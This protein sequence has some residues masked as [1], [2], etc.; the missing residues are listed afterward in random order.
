MSIYKALNTDECISTS[1][2]GIIGHVY[3]KPSLEL[4]K[5]PENIT[6][7]D[8]NYSN[9]I[10]LQNKVSENCIGYDINTKQIS[11]MLCD[12]ENT[13]F[14]LMQSTGVTESHKKDVLFT[15]YNNE[16]NQNTYKRHLVPK[17]INPD[18]VSE[19][20]Y[21]IIEKNKKSIDMANDDN[22]DCYIYFIYK[23][24]NSEKKKLFL[25]IDT[26][27]GKGLPSKPRLRYYDKKSKR[28]V[29]TL[30][31]SGLQNKDNL[32]I[33]NNNK[34]KIKANN[35][36]L[37]LDKNKLLLNSRKSTVFSMTLYGY[38]D[39]FLFIH[40]LNS[41]NITDT[42]ISSFINPKK[43]LCDVDDK[44]GIYNYN[45]NSTK[46][47]Y[48]IKEGSNS[49]VRIGES[50][51]TRY[52]SINPTYKYENTLND[53]KNENNIGKKRVI[54]KNLRN[55][56]SEQN[57]S[58]GIF[59]NISL[60]TDLSLRE[61]ALKILEFILEILDDTKKIIEH[62]F[63]SMLFPSFSNETPY[64][65][66]FDNMN[67]KNNNLTNNF[68]KLNEFIKDYKLYV[69]DVDFLINT[70]K[71]I[72]LCNAFFSFMFNKELYI[73]G[74]YFPN[75][76]NIE[77]N[78]TKSNLISTN[79]K[80][81]YTGIIES[82]EE[83]ISNSYDVIYQNNQIINAIGEF[84]DYANFIFIDQNKFVINNNILLKNSKLPFISENNGYIYVLYRV[85]HC[86]D[87]YFTLNDKLLSFKNKYMIDEDTL[88]TYDFNKLKSIFIN[89]DIESSI[90]AINEITGTSVS[91]YD[92]SALNILKN[93]DNV[94]DL[95]RYIQF[96]SYYNTNINQNIIN[97]NS[98]SYYYAISTL[99]N[100]INSKMI[101]ALNDSYCKKIDI[102]SGDSTIQLESFR[103]KYSTNNIKEMFITKEGFTVF[104]KNSENGGR[105]SL[106]KD[107]SKD[108][109]DTTFKDLLKDIKFNANDTIFTYGGDNLTS[110]VSGNF[111]KQ[112]V[113]DS[114]GGASKCLAG[115]G[116]VR[117]IS[118][119]LDYSCNNM[120][121]NETI[122][123]NMFITGNCNKS[124]ECNYSLV[125]ESTVNG[126][127]IELALNLYKDSSKVSSIH[128]ETIIDV[129]MDNIIPFTPENGITSLNQDN[130][131]IKKSSDPS[132]I[133][134]NDALYSTDFKFRY[135]LMVDDNNNYLKL[136]YRTSPCKNNHGENINDIQYN[137]V[138]N[139][140]NDMSMNAYDKFNKFGY[141][142]IKGHL[143]EY[144]EE[145]I[146]LSNDYISYENYAYHTD[147]EIVYDVNNNDSN[148]IGYYERNGHQISIKK[149]EPDS[150]FYP[151]NGGKVFLKK[152]Y[153]NNNSID[154][155]CPSS[156]DFTEPTSIKV[157]DEYNTTE[158]VTIG[159]KCGIHDIS[160]F[161]KMKNDY[162]EAYINLNSTIEKLKQTYNSL[163]EQEKKLNI[164]ILDEIDNLEKNI[165]KQEEIYNNINNNK[166]SK[167]K[168]DVAHIETK[169]VF[170]KNELMFNIVGII[171]LCA[172]V[173]TFR[174][175]K[176]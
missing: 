78:F 111:F 147:N 104:S 89:I 26:K 129:K 127:N 133:N 114:N 115:D 15:Y 19:F 97:E 70:M 50:Q 59:F 170:D 73:Q 43:S 24:K 81:S 88:I 45:S 72:E 61:K 135:I 166:K 64:N 99:L 176:K 4:K 160:E 49:N 143:S 48:N 46:C 41:N 8:N 106:V 13:S 145:D 98:I 80:I 57:L 66:Y 158:K 77:T 144:N 56:I 112:I 34:V 22:I 29:F 125:I 1:D 140:E 96:Y 51:I 110:D 82:M 131:Y 65:Q 40:E 167:E 162:E 11:P 107:S 121:Y 175:I 33:K 174:S 32:N 153:V 155:S 35:L 14:E 161:S 92:Y 6:S 108:Y 120:A 132:S 137:S 47:I 68:N 21:Q 84:Q 172:I 117:D 69:S 23:L 94:N 146:G 164:D 2:T 101:R 130:N 79:E 100:E 75:Y 90:N 126:E 116:T 12:N 142:N 20:N 168:Y 95:C 7:F 27:Q 91:L 54:L 148:I 60:I 169:H 5:C 38:I 128:T 123:D 39:N 154:S 85:F 151:L 136:Q 74:M 93:S 113:Y 102:E 58:N 76:L 28:S 55:E 87:L 18:N 3:D 63:D 157:W 118:F 53:V 163:T 71:I 156:E 149:N 62:L 83:F 17:I 36:Y 122:N 30:E 124:S 52:N 105:L 119:N 86:L 31:R 10:K 134:T 138:F 16:D 139:I 165:L 141:V 44:V 9:K 42:N 103:N 152:K 25:G 109:S 173:Y 67:K 159:N 171:S 150:Y 37:H